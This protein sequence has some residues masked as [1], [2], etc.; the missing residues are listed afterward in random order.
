MATFIN[1]IKKPNG[2]DYEPETCQR[3]LGAITKHLLNADYGYNLKEH[4]TSNYC[5]E[6]LEAKKKI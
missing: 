5:R 1:E 4:I 2:S 3:F 6:V